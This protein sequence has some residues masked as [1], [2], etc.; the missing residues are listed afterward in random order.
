MT[1]YLSNEDVRTLLPMDECVDLMEQVFRDEA[2]GKAVNLPRQHL[3]LSKGFHRTVQ[4]IAEGFGVYGMKTYGSD[5]RPNAPNRTRYLVLLYSLE[6]GGLD[7]IVDARDLGQIRT[8]AVSGLATKYMAR[9]DATT[10]G[11]IG[12]GWEA[13]AQI[14]AMSV[15]RNISHVKAYSRS[16]ENREAFSA[17]M[18]EKHGLDVDPVDTA[19][20]AA[21]DVDILVTI[22]GA[23]EPVMSGE[24]LVPGMHVNAIGAT[25]T[26]RRELDVEAVRR[27]D[28]IVVELLEQSKNDSGELLDAEREGVFDWS[29]VTELADIVVGKATGRPSPE[30]ITQFNALGVGTE[31]LAAA[32]VVYRKAIESGMGTELAM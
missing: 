8:G 29:N 4:G 28:L 11:I 25:G 6:T 23:N 5:R 18:R 31:D 2:D 20:E 3:P 15:V 13:R 21:R 30:A 26:N 16:A 19:E 27:S 7:A 22:T 14:A 24:W 17:E 32:S 9:E 1:I 12:T 10:L